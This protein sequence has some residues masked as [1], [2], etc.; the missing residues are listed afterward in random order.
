MWIKGP[1]GE[2]ALYQSAGHD[3]VIEFWALSAR[4][5]RHRKPRQPLKK[6]IGNSAKSTAIQIAKGM[7]GAFEKCAGKKA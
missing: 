2:A 7:V 3:W 4:S 5:R 6:T 1:K